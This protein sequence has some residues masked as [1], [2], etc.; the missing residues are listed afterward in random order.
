[1]DVM[2]LVDNE[3]TCALSNAIGQNATR[4]LTANLTFSVTITYSYGKRPYKCAHDGC[5]KSFCRKTT[6]VKHQDVP[7]NAVFIH[8][9]F[10]D[11]ETSDSESGESPTTPRHHSNQIQWGQHL[12]VPGMS[13]AHHMQRAHSFGDCGPQQIDGFPM[14]QAFSHRHSLSGGAQAYGP[15]P[16]QHH[17][18]QRQPSLQSAS[19]YVPEQ[20]N[21]ASQ[22]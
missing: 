2:E 9:S 4:V 7:I 3:Q 18:V 13:Q 5:L 1:M 11:G 15:I 14:Q 16:D 22:L 17:I 19:Y 10:D 21:Q 8:R 20:N 12:G 6:M